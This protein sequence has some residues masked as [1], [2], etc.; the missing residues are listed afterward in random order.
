MM[1]RTH[2]GSF[3]LNRLFKQFKPYSVIW[4]NMRLEVNSNRFEMSNRFEKLFHLHGN[5]TA[6]N[7]EVS[8]RFQKL[9][10]LHGYFIASTLQTMAKLYCTFA[11]DI[12]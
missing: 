10:R 8:N 11:N 12:F 5:F 4:P 3:N 6:S 7:L 9:F 1:H 2:S